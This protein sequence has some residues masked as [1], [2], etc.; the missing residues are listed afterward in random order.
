MPP[1]RMVDEGARITKELITHY[2]KSGAELAAIWAPP[3]SGKTA[4]LVSLAS[5]MAYRVAAV[6][7]KRLSSGAVA[8]KTTGT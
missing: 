8:M 4:L 2:S 7:S 5:R 6:W 3:G 1:A